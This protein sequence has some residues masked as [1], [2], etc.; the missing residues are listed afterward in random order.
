MNKKEVCIII[1]K[2][3]KLKEGTVNENSTASDIENWDSL[4]HISLIMYLDTNYNDI[5]KD[6]PEYMT[7]TSVDDLYQ[8]GLK[9]IEYI[10]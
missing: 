1:E 10:N 5:T 9:D 8:A 4:G 7:A 2:V 3:L 6:K